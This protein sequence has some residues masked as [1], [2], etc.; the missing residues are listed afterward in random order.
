MM[1][2]DSRFGFAVCEIGKLDPRA[3]LTLQTDLVTCEACKTS[4][5]FKQRLKQE[6]AAQKY[7]AK[8]IAKHVASCVKP[9]CERCLRA[10]RHKDPLNT[11]TTEERKG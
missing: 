5:R 11:V 10:A 6:A 9:N 3:P 4:P 7:I 8:A 1:H 2:L